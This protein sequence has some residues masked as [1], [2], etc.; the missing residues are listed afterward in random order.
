MGKRH[1]AIPFALMSLTLS[2]FRKPDRR[3]FLAALVLFAYLFKAIIPVGYMPDLKGLEEGSFKITICTAQ[4]S[5]DITVGHNGQPANPGG[6]KKSP[7]NPC[8]FGGAAKLAL[9]TFIPEFS[10]MAFAFFRH[11]PVR[12]EFFIAPVLSAAA[13]PRAPPALERA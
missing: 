1:S 2:H 7:D 5:A 11:K 3:V 4:G 12:R 9:K 6:E 10:Q 13:Q 8:F